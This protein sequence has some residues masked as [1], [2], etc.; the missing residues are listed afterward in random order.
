[1]DYVVECQRARREA[2]ECTTTALL[3]LQLVLINKY[4]TPTNY[5]SQLPPCSLAP[6]SSSSHTQT[7]CGIRCC[8]GI[9]VARPRLK[10]RPSN[11]RSACGERVSV[12]SSL[13]HN[14]A[15]NRSTAQVDLYCKVLS[16]SFKLKGTIYYAP[17]LQPVDARVTCATVLDPS[18]THIRTTL[19]KE[20]V[21][22][23]VLMEFYDYVEH[24]GAACT[25]T[26]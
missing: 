5:T 24:I 16:R 19:A 13:A 22:G 2:S 1:V 10:T 20:S 11:G 18:Y 21:C 17:N 6:W 3:P 4:T 15:T 8:P 25:H 23:A 9:T 26:E 12:E 14:P 7:R